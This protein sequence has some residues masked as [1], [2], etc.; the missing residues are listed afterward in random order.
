MQLFYTPTIQGSEFVLNDQE[1]KHCIRVLRLKE[2]SQIHLT[3][4][5]GGLFTAEIIEPSPKACKLRIVETIEEY[6][7]RSYKL[8]IAIAPT[9]NIERLEWFLEKATEIGIDEI[10]PILCEHSERKQIK[11]ERL[12]RIIVSAMKQSI[13]AYKPKLNALTPYAEFILGQNQKKNTFIAHCNKG[14][15]KNLKEIWNQGADTVIL[16]GPEGDF[17]PKEV[18]LAVNAGFKSIGLGKSRLRTE[19]AGVVACHSIAFLNE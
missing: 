6:E 5:V 8:H 2:G 16:I 9:K 12:E 19:T 10:T 15:K 1:S 13:K 4:G 3:N 18:D 11:N 14:E 7:K 17:S